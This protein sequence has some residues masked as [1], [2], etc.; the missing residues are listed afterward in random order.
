M[1]DLPPEIRD[2]LEVPAQPIHELNPLEMFVPTDV[3][4][5]VTERAMRRMSEKL[6]A[7]AIEMR[8]EMQRRIW[9]GALQQRA[10]FLDWLRRHPDAEIY[11]AM[12]PVH[13]DGLGDE[14]GPPP[15]DADGE[16]GPPDGMDPEDEDRLPF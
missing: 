7:G 12:Y 14:T 15:D 10:D 3:L 8:T 11:L 2:A 1:H 6:A 9:K 4:V 16:E 13:N 5:E